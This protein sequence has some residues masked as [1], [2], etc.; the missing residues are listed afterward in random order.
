MAQIPQSSSVI[1][2]R[3]P[4][5]MRASFAALASRHQ[6]SES[7][8]LAKLIDDVLTAH[9]AGASNMSGRWGSRDASAEGVAANR[10]TLRLRPG[11]RALATQ[12]AEARGMK[13]GSYLVMLIHNH[14]HGSTVMPPNELG[15]IKAV[16]AQLAALGRQLKVFGMPN[17]LAQKVDL[18]PGD[19]LESIR[20]EVEAAREATAAVVR[21]N[22][23]SW[24][25]NR[26][27]GHA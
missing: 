24:E 3:V 21:W 22:L 1:S 14:V 11:D 2:T 26:E 25:T 8:L 20:R 13:T 12:R 18:E 10:I 5:G 27:A 7:S 17:T 4:L 9:G 15:Q 23:M 6:L 19:A 16:C